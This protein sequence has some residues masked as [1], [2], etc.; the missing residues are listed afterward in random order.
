MPIDFS[1]DRMPITK[2]TRS[3]GTLRRLVAL[4]GSSA[5]IA[6]SLWMNGCT[7]DSK[8]THSIALESPRVSSGTMITEAN[9]D[10]L[11][12]IA[13]ALQDMDAPAISPGILTSLEAKIKREELQANEMAFVTN[14]L[15]QLD[16]EGE[17]AESSPSHQANAT[18]FDETK[19]LAIPSNAGKLITLQRMSMP[20]ISEL[21]ASISLRFE[22]EKG[23][24]SGQVSHRA[25]LGPTPKG[26]S[27]GPILV[28][29]EADGATS[30]L[31]FGF[32]NY[33]SQLPQLWVQGVVVSKDM[34]AAV[35]T[36]LEGIQ[37]YVDSSLNQVQQMRTELLQTDVERRII[38]LSYVDTAGAMNALKGLGIKTVSDINAMPE[39]FQY[40]QLPMVTRL[41]EPTKEQM[42][43]VG[44]VQSSSGKFGQTVTPNNASSLNSDVN[45]GRTSQL[46]IVYHPAHPEQF[47]LVRSLLDEYIDRPA[48]LVFVE[49]LVL[50][51]SEDGLDELG[52]EWSYQ[53]GAASLIL[54]SLDPTGLIDTLDFNSLDSRDLPRDWG[55]EIKALISDGKAE[56]LS[57]PSVLTM[58]NRQATIRVGEDIPIATSQ[59]GVL[60]NSNKVAF[61]F[62][63]LPTGILL[64]IR[65]RLTE[66]GDE[67]SMLIDTVVSAQVPGQDL[68][69]R[70]ADG[71]LLAS[72][73]RIS[74]RRVQTYA[75][76]A[77]TTPFI[78]GGLVSRDESI[79]EDKV[80]LLGDLPL[81]GPAFRSS[82]TQTQ[83]R[84]V[85]IV[86]TPYVLPEDQV[87]TR[88]LP[89]DD[90]LFDNTGNQLFRDA[91]RIRGEDVFDLRFLAENK[92]LM[93]YRNLA[94]DLIRNNFK[95]AYQEPFNQFANDT[96]PGEEILIQ[97][98]IYEVIKRTGVD[99]RINPERI[100]YFEAKDY[101]GYDVQFLDYALSQLGD[102]ISANS[103][104][105]RNSGKAV[106]ITY[107]YSRNSLKQ[108][109]LA[110]EPI[111]E[112]ALVDCPNRDTWQ[113]LLWDMNQPTS[114]GIEQFTI[115]L[116]S[117]DDVVRLQRALMLKKIILL[118]GGENGLSLDNFSIGKILHTPK[119]G[120]DKVNVIDADVA[121]YFYHTELYYAAIIKKIEDTLAKFDAQLQEP[122]IQ[123]YLSSPQMLPDIE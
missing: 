3:W 43:L 71:D 55:V 62:Q 65:P 46:M 99:D 89:K 95:L 82:R 119:L 111:P 109:D 24:T 74:T 27:N 104:F 13:Q 84:E 20:E 69:I 8:Q 97:R 87:I 49:G 64:N 15:E 79:I 16:M 44:D 54:G 73:P 93:I 39:K 91:Y 123:M 78:I 107:T 25:L 96:V 120:E 114:A 37:S 30:M 63:Y 58:N 40:D 18:E 72:A 70:S 108:R 57:R 51:I 6:G 81:I 94:K 48:R 103:F 19:R 106:A 31:R 90:D 112:I 92:R 116:H 105:E 85:I 21:I 10:G 122:G 11:A 68:E 1:G 26:V 59:E 98:M 75:R 117:Q 52:V 77:N 5:V 83:K 32:V 80:P 14:G 101:E 121:R 2:I 118:N 45:A 34:V 110:S 4:S 66:N 38:Q 102:G 42:G 100:I 50:E 67:V 33:L 29:Q 113:Q 61:N 53:E 41:P 22:T 36:D 115:L 86:L 47:S 12:R 28:R 88:A 56:I 76:I 17:L 23:Y 7:R 35:N 9:D 60:N